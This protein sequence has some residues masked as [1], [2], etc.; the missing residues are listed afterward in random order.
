MASEER[1]DFSLLLAPLQIDRLVLSNRIVMPPMVTFLAG[2]DGLVTQAHLEHYRRSSGPGL[3]I[4]EGTAVSPEGR[5][6]RHQLGIYSNQQIYGLSQLARSI[7]STGAVAGIQIHHAGAK[8]FRE[9]REPK[10]RRLIGI[11]MRLGRQQ[12]MISGLQH[13]REAFKNAGRRAVE[14]GFDII[15]IHGAHGYLFSQFLSPLKNWRVDRYGGSIENRQRLLLEV[16]KSVSE[17][18]AG[19]ALVTCRLG[20]ADRSSRGLALSDGLSAASALVKAGARLL[21]ISSGIGTPIHVRPAGSR[22]SGRLHLAH[23]V[24][25]HLAAKVPVIGCGGIRRP[26]FAEQALQEGMA[27]LIAVGKG[28]LADPAWARKIIEGKPES[29]VPCRKCRVCFQFTDYSKCPARRQ[30]KAA[31][32][33]Y[34]LPNQGSG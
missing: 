24:K 3:I 18:V 1:M 19:R 12:I 7:H 4:V 23:E 25:V 13:I 34:D 30:S 26:E 33:N 8:A 27:D 11:F 28:I 21:D 17:E 2:Y 14:A 20:V 6:N 32:K 15:E 31:Q 29:I 10:Y 22:Y 5:I 16:Y 9:T